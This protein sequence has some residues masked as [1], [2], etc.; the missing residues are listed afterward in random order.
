MGHAS[1]AI[2]IDRYGHLMPGGEDEAAAK[3]SAFLE[4]GASTLADAR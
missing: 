2:T 4:R 3:L 1:A